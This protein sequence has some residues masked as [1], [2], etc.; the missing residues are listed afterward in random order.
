MNSFHG[1]SCNIHYNSDLSGEIEIIRTVK[2]KK[3]TAKMM[4][5]IEGD[6]LKEF[7]RQWIELQKISAI[8]DAPLEKLIGL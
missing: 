7:M 2:G 1:K 4:L 6:D 8:E 5:K 3:A